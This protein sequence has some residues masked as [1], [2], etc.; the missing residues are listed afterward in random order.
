[1]AH[2]KHSEHK[3]E[4]HDAKDIRN[5]GGAH[6]HSDINVRAVFGFLITLTVV[7]IVIQLGL[8]GMFRYLKGSYTALDP[9]PNPMLSGV[10]QPPQHD[11]IRD[12]PQPRLQKDPVQDVDKLRVAE[13][14]LLHDPPA[15]VDEKAGV[16]R[17]PIEQAMQLTLARGLPTRMNSPPAN[18]VPAAT[19]T[20]GATKQ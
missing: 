5:P 18:A 4:H 17:I 2:D 14:K 10:R 16:V 8:W 6:E 20:K 19:K 12:F 1:M 13:D 11:P 15:W 3:H 7:A 9:E